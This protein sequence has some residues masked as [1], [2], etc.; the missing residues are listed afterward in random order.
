MVLPTLSYSVNSATAVAI[1]LNLIW[2]DRV[3][4]ND[5]LLN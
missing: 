4:V 5:I 3:I 1:D 2:I